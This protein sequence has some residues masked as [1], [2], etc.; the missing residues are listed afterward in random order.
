MTLWP[1]VW[2]TQDVFRVTQFSD[3]HFCTEPEGEPRNT[4]D[5]WDAVFADAFDS[6]RPLLD[7]VV[8]TG[9]IAHNGSE[10]EYEKIAEKLASLPVPAVVCPG[11]HDRQ[12]PFDAISPRPGL[13]NGRTMRVGNW[14]FL[15]ADSNAAG[16]DQR[17]DGSLVDREDRTEKHGRFGDPEVVWIAETVD[18]SDAD[19]AFV[20][21]H[22]PPGAF[23]FFSSV[24]HDI[25]FGRVIDMAPA[26]RGV[27]AGH[28]HT[29][30]TLEC[31]ERPI[32]QCP[33]LS[34]NIDLEKFTTL[35]PGYRTYEFAEDGSITSEAHL[36]GENR[37]PR[38]QLAKVVQR[39]LSGEISFE[40]MRAKLAAERA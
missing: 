31:A 39:M 9:D 22:H 34:V 2:D 18:R 26:I 7:L 6:G 5:T 20:W 24:D 10:A 16:R 25:E 4:D 28:T 33:S 35:P 1:R 3:M 13:S 38:S 17:P 15:F 8:L 40:E 27:G 12:V 19:H 11:N 29:N 36:V 23:G 21:T 14:L 32:H 37:W 30:T